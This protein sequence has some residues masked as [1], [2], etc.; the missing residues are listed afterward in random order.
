MDAVFDTMSDEEVLATATWTL[1]Q[2][3]RQELTDLIEIHHD[4]E[5]SNMERSRLDELMQD[6]RRML[7]R[8][9]QATEVAISRGIMPPS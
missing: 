8:K 7:V 3:V 1:S 9:A 5:L 2:Y 6:Y 4:R